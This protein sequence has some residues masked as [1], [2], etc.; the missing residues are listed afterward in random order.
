MLRTIR[1]LASALIVL[2]LVVWGG[3]FLAARDP[4]G[5]VGEAVR[6]VAVLTGLRADAAP[7]IGS[8]VA[9]NVQIG[10]PFHLVNQD[11][12]D[13]TDADF[14]GRWML[15][16]FGYTYCP[17][18]CPT[19]LQTIAA[20]LDKLGANA[21]AVAP[22]FITVDPARDTPQVLKNYVK[23]FDSRLVGLTGTPQQIADVAK[24]YHVYYAR[25]GDGNSANY[26]MDH[27]SFLYL[28]D[29]SGHFA[30]LFR[31]GMSP[32]DLAAGIA[33]RLRQTS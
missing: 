3:L 11:G 10:G 14:R 16:Y 12:R 13:V 28:M 5:P 20:A 33:A 32:D 30:A 4:S 6:R 9:G 27:S 7:G 23:L 22:V 8:Q 31:P 21:K 26:T 18:V 17:D 25:A 24:R 29:P 15:V 2:V 19:E 1:W